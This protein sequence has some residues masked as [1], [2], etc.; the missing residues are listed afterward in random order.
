MRVR[1]EISKKSSRIQGSGL[2]FKKKI[3]E[4]SRVRFEI[5]EKIL[6]DSRVRFEIW[7]KSS[8]IQGVRFE[9][10]EKILEDSRVRFEKTL[11]GL[12]SSRIPLVLYVEII[13]IL[14]PL[15]K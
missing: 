4:D 2:G 3:L 15:T 13:R 7:P 1:F 6:E 11:E 8:R 12:G 14:P 9:I 10:L 5:L